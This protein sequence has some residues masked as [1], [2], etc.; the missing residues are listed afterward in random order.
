MKNI[1]AK[2]K[3][4]NKVMKRVVAYEVK[5]TRTWFLKVVLGLLLAL[6]IFLFSFWLTARDLIQSRTLD[7]LSLFR[8]DFEIIKDYWQDTLVTVWEELPRNIIFICD[9]SIVFLIALFI[10]LKKKLPFMKNKVS[11]INKYKRKINIK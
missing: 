10:F 11:A 6:V 3:M 8:E 1:K 9:A 5:K 2:N 7:L 4:A